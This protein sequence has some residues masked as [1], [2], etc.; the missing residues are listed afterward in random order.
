MDNFHPVSVFF[1][2]D[3]EQSLSFY[4]NTLG[5]ELDWNHQEQGRAYVVKVSLFGFELI[6]NQVEPG[7]EGRGVGHGRVFIGL[8]DDQ[9]VRFRQHLKAKD[10]KPTFTRWGGPTFVI[11][12]RDRNEMFFW[13]P[14]TER[15]NLEAELAGA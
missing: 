3:A 9:A 10:I 8:N 12:D 1:V 4:T 7:T 15:A 6:L 14:D 13:L 5:F 11:H 2:Q